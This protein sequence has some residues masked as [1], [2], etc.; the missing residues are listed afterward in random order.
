MHVAVHLYP[1]RSIS[2]SWPGP[3]LKAVESVAKE[4]LDQLG[5]GFK[6][7]I[8]TSWNLKTAGIEAAARVV[9]SGGVL[10][11]QIY[12]FAD[13]IA[14]DLDAFQTVFHKL[15]HLGLSTK[16]PA[17]AADRCGRF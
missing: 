2:P 17:I 3:A 6:V 7:R 9:P 8:I 16:I 11:G 14:S 4:F 5:V 15:I 1:V 13:N 12:L 10:N